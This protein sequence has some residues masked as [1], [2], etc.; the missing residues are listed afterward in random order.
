LVIIFFYYIFAKKLKNMGVGIVGAIPVSFCLGKNPYSYVPEYSSGSIERF[1]KHVSSDF[2]DFYN[3][4]IEKE[5]NKEITYYKIKPE[6]LLPNFKEFYHEFYELVH[7]NNMVEGFKKF[8]EK[9]D[10]I[11]SAN[12]LDALMEYFDD[13]T[14]SAPLNFPYFDAAFITKNKNILVYQGSY[15]ALLEDWSTLK[16]MELLLRVAMKNPLAKVMRFGMSE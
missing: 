6:I 2:F 15:N 8:N 4:V 5:D 13:G 3:Q 14:G 7:D 10:V 11:V 9:Y 12:D 1:K 16:H